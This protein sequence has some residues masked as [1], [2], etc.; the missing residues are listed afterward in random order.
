MQVLPVRI[1]VTEPFSSW[2]ERVGHGLVTVRRVAAG[3]PVQVRQPRD[4]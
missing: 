1:D 3:N 4:A 2:S